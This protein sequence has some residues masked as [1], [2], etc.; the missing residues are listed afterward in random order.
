MYTSDQERGQRVAEQLEAGTA[1]VNHMSWTY[2]SMP[3]GGVKK[4]SYGC[5]LGT[6]GIEEFVNKKLIRSFDEDQKPVIVS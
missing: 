5:E 3:V 4:S 1:F 2:A 6:L